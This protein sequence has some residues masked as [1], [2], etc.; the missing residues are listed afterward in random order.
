MG[1]LVSVVVVNIVMEH[2]E[3]EAL[4]ISLVPMIFWNGYADEI[5]SAV[6]VGQVN[7][8]LTHIYSTD[9]NIQFT[10]ERER[11]RSFVDVVI[12]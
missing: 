5:L 2:I 3:S 6:S 7:E 12:C 8:M 9:Q 11:E 1:S 10:S 4:S